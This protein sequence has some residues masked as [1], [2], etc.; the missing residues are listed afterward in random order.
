MADEWLLRRA[1]EAALDRGESRRAARIALRAHGAELFGFLR[2]VVDDQR[3]ARAAYDAL[4]DRVATDLCTFRWRCRLRIWLFSA[5]RAVLA[6]Q[7][8]LGFVAPSATARAPSLSAALGPYRRR[9]RVGPPSS[10]L[11]SLSGAD[12]ELFVLRVGRRVSFRDL[13]LTSLGEGA[14]DRR[15]RSEEQR[16]RRQLARIRSDLLRWAGSGAALDQPPR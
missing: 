10:L 7:R 2:A 5:V 11:R 14:S 16:L 4:T 15:L 12:R 8:R 3:T 13:A 1:I 9:A 6:H